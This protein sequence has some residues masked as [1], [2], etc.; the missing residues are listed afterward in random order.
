MQCQNLLQSYSNQG[1]V[2]PTKRQ[3]HTNKSMGQKGESRNRSTQI[4]STDL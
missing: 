1:R 2:I 3:T 4:Q